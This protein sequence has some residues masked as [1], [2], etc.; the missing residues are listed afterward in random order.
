MKTRS[1]FTLVELVVV[2]MILGILA[3]VAAPKL[4]NTSSQATENGLRATLSI[5]RN[6]IELFAAQNNGALPSGTNEAAFKTDLAN[7]VRG[8][9]PTSPFGAADA[10][11]QIVTGTTPAGDGSNG[12]L[13]NSDTGEF[14]CDDASY[15]NF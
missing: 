13:Y 3:G 1:A 8:D 2:I 9:F 15:D 4:L 5:V 7:Y 10:T 12:W 11:V 14:V 6:G